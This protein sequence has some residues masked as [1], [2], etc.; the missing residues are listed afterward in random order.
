MPHKSTSTNLNKYVSAIA[1]AMDRGQEVHAIYT[2]FS[3]AF[4]TV[5]HGILIH[6]LIKI[7]INANLIK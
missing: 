5:E 1:E 7:G 6:K 3:K 2:D 4:D